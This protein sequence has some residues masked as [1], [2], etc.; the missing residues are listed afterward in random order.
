MGVLDLGLE[1][2]GEILFEV[3][4]DGRVVGL[5]TGVVEFQGDEGGVLLHIGG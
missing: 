5:S 3:E 4:R 2:G 1:L